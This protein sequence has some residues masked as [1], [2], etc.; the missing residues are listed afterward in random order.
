[1]DWKQVER[2]LERGF[3]ARPR[4]FGSTGVIERR[5]PLRLAATMNETLTQ[6]SR[7]TQ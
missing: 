3:G 5:K 7:P 4:R 1:V 6:N 2:Q